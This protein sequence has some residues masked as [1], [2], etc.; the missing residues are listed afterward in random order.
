MLFSID[1]EAGV[2]SFNTAP[3][4]DTPGDADGGN[5]YEIQ[6]TVPVADLPIAVQDIT[7]TVE[8][9]SENDAP[10]ITRPA[11]STVPGRSGS[12]FSDRRL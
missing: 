11:T 3:D 1:H 5:D 8:S 12:R 7:V 9:V 2:L 4:F 10:T 6:V